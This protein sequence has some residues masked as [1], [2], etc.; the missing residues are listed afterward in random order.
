MITAPKF[1]IFKQSFR[2]IKIDIKNPPVNIGHS[3]YNIDGLVADAVKLAKS[4][5]NATTQFSLSLDPEPTY[6]MFSRR[7]NGYTFDGLIIDCKKKITPELKPKK[8]VVGKI[9]SKVNAFL[10]TKTEKDRT[11]LDASNFEGEAT[12]LK[13]LDIIFANLEDQCDTK[14][15]EKLL[16]KNSS[17]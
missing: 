16:K 17:K 15:S 2:P 14:H 9:L 3:R 13:R 7:V 8:T 5:N 6:E 10:M 12:P 1:N 4:K 11:T